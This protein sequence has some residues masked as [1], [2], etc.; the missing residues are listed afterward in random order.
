MITPTWIIAG[1]RNLSDKKYVVSALNEYANAHGYP[2]EVVSGGSR[3]ADFLGE[4]WAEQ[5]GIPV[6]RFPADWDKYG[7]S[8][9]PI[10]NGQM[11]EYAKPNGILLLFWDGKSPG[12]RSMLNEAR[13]RNIPVVQ[14]IVK[15]P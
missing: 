13:K 7:R 8:A 12:S 6:K 15:I 5:N 9:G 2:C 3:G 11:A 14:F 10:R 4:V 1:S